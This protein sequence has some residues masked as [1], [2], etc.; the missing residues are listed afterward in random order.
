MNDVMSCLVKYKEMD[1]NF[2]RVDPRTLEMILKA[3]RKPRYNGKSI[4]FLETHINSNKNKVVSLS[5]RQACS[6]EAAG[7][8][9]TKELLRL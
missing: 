2:K 5:I 9:M 4:F 6:V 8:M 1:L 3:K 7:K